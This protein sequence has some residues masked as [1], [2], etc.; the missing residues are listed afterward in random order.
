MAEINNGINM[1][2]SVFHKSK[3]Y[4]MVYLGAGPFDYELEKF[5]AMMA[6]ESIEFEIIEPFGSFMT[7]SYIIKIIDESKA[8]YFMLKYSIKTLDK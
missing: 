6:R 2:Y 8:T 7:P 5:E 4:F 3:N 1:N